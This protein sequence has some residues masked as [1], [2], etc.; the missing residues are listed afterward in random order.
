MRHKKPEKRGLIMVLHDA[1]GN[2]H[3]TDG[4]FTEKPH[5]PSQD[6][7]TP[8]VEL[9]PLGEDETP[10]RTGQKYYPGDLTYRSIWDNP[11]SEGLPK[12]IGYW[13]KDGTLAYAKYVSRSE[14][15]PEIVEFDENR[16]P[17]LLGYAPRRDRLQSVEFTGGRIVEEYGPYPLEVKTSSG[18]TIQVSGASFGMDGTPIEAQTQTG[19]VRGQDLCKDF[20]LDTTPGK[21]ATRCGVSVGQAQA[22]TRAAER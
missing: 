22:L 18:E 14:N 21:L 10:T 19:V 13:A 9:F 12:E 16:Q 1:N 20:R 7:D 17:T 8:T 3:G 4:R 2:L 11:R 5:N 6:L 15:Q